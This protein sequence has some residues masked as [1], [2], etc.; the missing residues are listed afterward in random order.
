MALILPSNYLAYLNWV[1]TGKIVQKVT[2]LLL[3]KHSIIVFILVL[4]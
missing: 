2:Y 1:K 3:K 4:L